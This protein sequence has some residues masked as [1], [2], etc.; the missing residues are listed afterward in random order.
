MSESAAPS[1]RSTRVLFRVG[2]WV[3]LVVFVLFAVNHIAGIWLIASSTDESQMF[4]LFGALNVLALIVL[5]I[6]YRR[7][8]RWAWWAMW[9][10]IV[11]VGLVMA[12]GAGA[13]G[14]TYLVTAIVLALAQFATLPRFLGTPSVQS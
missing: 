7:L 6:P 11:P 10:A 12:F 14:V 9:V 4:E 2:W 5:L 8:Q 13:I 3:L 1:P